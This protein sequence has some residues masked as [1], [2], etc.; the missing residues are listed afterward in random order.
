MTYTTKN[1]GLFIPSLVTPPKLATTGS[2]NTH[3]Y[4]RNQLYLNVTLIHKD[5]LLLVFV[6]FLSL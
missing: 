6:T 1:S 3:H 5:F 2:S 4:F